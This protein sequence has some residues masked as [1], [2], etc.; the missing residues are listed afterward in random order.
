VG[1][2]PQFSHCLLFNPTDPRSARSNTLLE[3]RMGPDEVHDVQN[4]AEILVDPEG[5]LERRSF[6]E[7]TGHS[8]LVGVILHVFYAESE[9]T[10]SRLATFLPDPPRRSFEHT[11]R[12]MLDKPL[13]RL[14]LNQ[15]ARRLT[16]SLE[17]DP[18]KRR[19]HLLLMILDELP[20][21]GRHAAARDNEQAAA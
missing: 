12:H 6:W 19:R 14:M 15:I 3:V 2:R 8:L 18:A 5:A 16:E 9:K 21:V 7:N 17:G 4:I 11:L 1:W 20:A 10:L 13:V